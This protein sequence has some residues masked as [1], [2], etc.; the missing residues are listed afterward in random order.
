MVFVTF[1][2]FYFFF[3]TDVLI[4]ELSQANYTLYDFCPYK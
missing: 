3:L 4:D 1:V 2:C